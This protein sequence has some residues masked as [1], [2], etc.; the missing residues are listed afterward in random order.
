MSDSF[1]PHMHYDR[2][3]VL[4]LFTCVVCIVQAFCF[5]D[6][7]S[8]TTGDNIDKH[9]NYLIHSIE[10]AYILAILFG[11]WPVFCFLI[12]SYKSHDL[13]FIILTESCKHVKAPRSNYLSWF[14]LMSRNLGFI[15]LTK[16]CKYVKAPRSNSFW[17][18]SNFLSYY[19]FELTSIVVCR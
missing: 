17:S 14:S 8:T 5:I 15:I 19:S 16:S 12:Q 6:E 7:A 11:N 13:G 4:S 2:V 1:P 10:N 18:I 3:V 9:K